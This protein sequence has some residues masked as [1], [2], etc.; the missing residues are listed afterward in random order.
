MKAAT[1]TRYGPP[2]VVTITQVEKPTPKPN[3]ILIKICATTLNSGDARMRRADFGSP[4]FTI[5]GRL[6]I[7]IRKPRKQIL[8]TTLAGEIESV[9]QE[10][11]KFNVGDPVFASA[12]MTFGAHAQYITIPQDAT[13]LRLPE[14]LSYEQAASIPFG[15]FTSI[16]FL[17]K[18]TAIKPNHRILINGA[19]GGVGSSAV[20]LAKHDGAHVTAVCSSNHFD[21]V[22]SIGADETI[23]YTTEDFTKRPQTYDIIFDSVG[24]LS[25]SKCK[26][27]LNHKGKF[28]TA[29]MNGIIILQILWTKLVANK[30]LIGGIAL[31]K[32]EHLQTLKDLAE[33]GAIKL[34]IDRAYPLDQI[35]QAHAYVDTGHKS[36]SVVITV[37]HD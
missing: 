24:K 2:E 21:L 27:A 14:N 17:R 6:M 12:G 22:K 10:V 33:S 29:E 4:L 37:N 15:G 36:G 31:D 26:R 3:E 11:T 28:I 34:T 18:L 25:F 9:G 5:L 13:V 16:H 8:G 19:A 20:Q 7:G 35:Q 23:D 32:P 1:Y 30:K